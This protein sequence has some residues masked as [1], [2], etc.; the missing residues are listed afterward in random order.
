MRRIFLFAGTTEGRRLAEALA[1]RALAERPMAVTVSVA[2]EYGRALL[3]EGVSVRVGRMNEADMI[4]H[5]AEGGYDLVVDAT[6]PYAAEAGDNIR[7]ACAAARVPRLRLAR[8]ESVGGDHRVGC[9]A[10]AVAWLAS[11][12]LAGAQGNVLLATG[13]KELDV[14]TA[15]PDYRERLYVRVLPAVESLERCL[16]LGFRP[17][18]LIAMQGPF[19][20]ALNVALLRQ[21]GIRVL[22]TK[23]GGGAGGFDEKAEACAAAGVR[24]LVIGR[25]LEEPGLSLEQV[26]AYIDG[27]LD[28]PGR[29]D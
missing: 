10:D 18:H 6:H 14:Y 3:P 25:P 16:A 17:D 21:W 8:P 27:I 5:L 11:D 2:T 23:D 13:A 15:V 29:K 28:Q 7:R 1:E 26:L 22:V 9:A 4:A 20:T 19:S 12:N 24:L